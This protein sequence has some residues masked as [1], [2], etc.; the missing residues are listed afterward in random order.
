[1]N[2]EI[3]NFMSR[4]KKELP[5]NACATITWTAGTS[6]VEFKKKLVLQVLIL[7]GGNKVWAARELKCGIRTI[8]MWTNEKWK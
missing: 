4:T 5:I 1:V 2:H 7:C 3:I 6:L 8:R